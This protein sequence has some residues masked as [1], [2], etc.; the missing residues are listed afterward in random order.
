VKTSAKLSL[1]AFGAALV[2]VPTLWPAS[3]AGDALAKPATPK[4]AGPSTAVTNAILDAIAEEMDRSMKEL[5]LGNLARPYHIAYKITE[6]DVNEVV[7]SL[8]YATTKRNNHFVNIEARVRVGSID[9][10]NGNFVVA[11]AESYDGV[12]AFTLPLEATPRIARRA[13]WLVTDSAYKEAIVQ[14]QY[15]HD[16]RTAAGGGK[17]DVPGWTVEPAV[18][19]ENPVD[20][21]AL[22]SLDEMEKA[23]NDLSAR[24]RDDEA[25]RDSRVAFSSYLERR[26]YI[27][28]E[29]TSTHDTRR[30][31][32]VLIAAF[33][34]AE[35]GQD[36]GQY[37]TKYG[38]TVA[39]LPSDKEL[40]AAADNLSSLI[41]KLAKAERID[42]YTGPVLFEGEG[43][44]GVVRYTL[45][46]HLGGTP[47]PE[48]LAPAAAKQFGGALADKVGLKVLANNLSI[49]DDP[50]TNTIGKQAVIGGYA[51][52]DEGVAAQKIQVVKDGMLE[53][54]LHS[55]TPSKKGEKS[56]GHARRTAPGGMFH[57][58]ATNL[59]IS[60]K[61]GLDRKKLVAKLLA[62]AK[63][64]GL[65][66]AII[67]KRMD[68]AAATA[69]PEM[70][71]RELVAM[72]Q[73][74]DTDLPPPAA[75]VYKV[76]PDGKEELVRGVQLGEVPVR[77][78]KDVIAVGKGQTVMNFLASGESF[79]IQ[80]LTG[81][82]IGS[83]PSSGI[84]SSV[85][86]PDLLFKELDLTAYTLGKRDKPAVPRPD[87]K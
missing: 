13:T 35:D 63:A 61:G 9:K 65:P 49:V 62:E 11:G 66:Y 81:V 68:D 14:Y 51:I 37:W 32:G 22:E 64:N 76:T 52:D 43:A 38:R 30:A 82:G 6:V 26:W 15:K 24:F 12:S 79:L 31:T 23:A 58:T 40:G 55:R 8:G 74:A 57:G 33:G 44:A 17:A 36:L 86:T 42:R 75:L 54:L 19:S 29:G 10:D 72:Y 4:Q 56:N 53:T 50:T 34:Q 80:K 83:V 7:S 84:E 2:V 1:I 46:P 85:A 45:A 60:G 16:A 27:N 28:S 25:V 5:Q 48:G 47:L 71:R 41:A 18:V 21:P 39:D 69:Q 73:N 67:I 3:D 59:I 70:T 78:W 87:G 77:A 20:V